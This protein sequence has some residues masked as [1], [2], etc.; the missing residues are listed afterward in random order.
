MAAL[1]SASADRS[2]RIGDPPGFRIFESH[3]R[4]RPPPQARREWNDVEDGDGAH[5]RQSDRGTS[6]RR[7]QAK[8]N[9]GRCDGKRWD[10]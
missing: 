1:S 10:R 8:K 2:E 7:I 4:R 9:R 3:A 5:G 6:S